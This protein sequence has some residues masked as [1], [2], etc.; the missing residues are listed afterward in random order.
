[1]SEILIRDKTPFVL[2]TGN[3]YRSI[4]TNQ[5]LFLDQMSYCAAG[6]SLD[7]F[8]K[9]YDVG[10]N[11]GIFP[12]EWLDSYEKLDYP[13]TDLRIEHF[14]SSLKNTRLTESDFNSLMENCRHNG[15]IYIKDLLKWYNNLDVR[16]MLKACLK[17]KEFYYSFNLDMYKD[18]MS[19]P[20]LSENIMFQFAIKECDEFL[21]EKKK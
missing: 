18:A 15:L 11:K 9:A 13:I 8:V 6:T 7:S 21:K 17:Q 16:P 20:G 14:D 12:Y 2:K 5:F 1:M 3:R 4:K 10:E 19:L